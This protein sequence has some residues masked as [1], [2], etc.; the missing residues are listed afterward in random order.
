MK[1]ILFVTL[2]SGGGGGSDYGMAPLNMIMNH[3]DSAPVHFQQQS[4]FHIPPPNTPLVV[5]TYLRTLFIL[6]YLLLLLSIL[7]HFACSIQIN[8]TGLGGKGNTL[9]PSMAST[10][11]VHSTASSSGGGSGGGSP[12]LGQHS[13]PMGPP[14]S[15]Q[16]GPP[17]PSKLARKAEQG[18]RG[19]YKV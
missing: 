19:Q 15:N 6:I 7:S 5:S 1:I 3:N 9:L 18:D 11:Q 2:I 4:P 8:F 14:N 12:T 10:Q 17:S 13:P 16:N